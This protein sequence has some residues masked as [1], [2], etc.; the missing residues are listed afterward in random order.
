MATGG[1][2]VELVH[3][4]TYLGQTLNNVYYFEAVVGG[5][6]LSQLAA[7]FE[8]NV[9]PAVKALQN[10][11]VTHT[12]LHLRN[13]FNLAEVWDEPLTGTGSILAGAGELP[14]FFASQLKLT[15]NNAL[16]RPGFK[17]ISGL[18]ENNIG[19]GVLE[20]VYRTGLFNYSQLL[21]NPP[22][23]A[24]PNWAHVIVNRI[25]QIPNPDPNATPV[26]LKYR[27]PNNQS[28]SD[29]GYPTGWLIY[30]EPTTQNSR[31]WYT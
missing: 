16:V 29:P 12:T 4:Q 31:K 3:T 24:N 25:C 11:L 6:S 17:R 2:I 30:G 8:T 22:S 10:D 26:C 28:E 9:V 14:A 20:T 23:A 21:I 13:L 1:D 5:A 15:H 7:W 18:T 19:D 27:L